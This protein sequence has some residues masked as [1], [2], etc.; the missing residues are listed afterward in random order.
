MLTSLTRAFS[1]CRDRVR[2]RFPGGAD[3]EFVDV[4]H[5]GHGQQRACCPLAGERAC[6]YTP[7]RGIRVALDL[8]V[9][10][11]FFVADSAT[12]LQEKRDLLTDELRSARSW[13]FEIC[14]R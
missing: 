4:P 1:I 10:P 2:R 5:L 6:P 7:L 3:H 13:L 12:F 8:E 9:F 11:Q 14:A